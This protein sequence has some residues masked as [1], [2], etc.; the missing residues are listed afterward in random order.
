MRTWAA[1]G[2]IALAPLT[3]AACSTDRATEPSYSSDVHPAGIADPASADFHGALLRAALYKPMMDG[4]RDDACGR[5]HQ[6]TP[7]AVPGVTLG[8]PGAPACTSCH[9]QPAGVLDCGTCH[10]PDRP[11]WGV[12]PS[13]VLSSPVRT[14]GYAC[15]TCHPLPPSQVIGGWH[16]DGHVEVIFDTAIVTPEA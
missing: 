5:C 16:A 10:G 12:H 6:G 15:S 13:H 7:G 9:T 14:A 3:G 8:A 11:G 4:S 2:L 1:A